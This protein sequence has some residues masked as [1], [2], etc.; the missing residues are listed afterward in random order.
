M[1]RRA[2]LRGVRLLGVVAMACVGLAL[3][4]QAALATNGR[5]QVVKIN[6]GGDPNDTFAFH[7]TFTWTGPLPMTASDFALKGGESSQTYDVACNIERPGHV[8]CSPH[9][10]NVTLQVAEQPTPGY[11]LTDI[12]CRSTQSDDNNNAFSAGPPGP[13]SP[14]KPAGEVSTD[15]ASGTVGLKVHYNEWVVCYFTNAAVA[16]VPTAPTPQ[17]AVGAASAA[18]PAAAPQIAVSPSRVRPGTAKMTGPSA[19]TTADVVVA[20]VTGRS[21]AR[22][23]FYVDNRKVKTL[24]KPNRGSTWMLSLRVPGLNY[25]S[26]R[27][28]ARVEFTRSSATKPRTLPMSFSRCGGG[29]VRPQFT[30]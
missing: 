16:V 4:A 10:S 26:H 20:R 5:V 8:E 9:Y 19:C 15:L 18:A 12:A 29:A 2:R 17:P 6:Q 30:G 11:S 25:G 13:G 3:S 24:R 21:I 1:S 23:T 28:K 27:V 7:P 14:V 22:V